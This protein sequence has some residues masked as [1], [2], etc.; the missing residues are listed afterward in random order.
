MSNIMIDVVKTEGGTTKIRFK[1]RDNSDATREDLDTLMK[2]IMG[3]YPKRAGYM[4][5]T[6]ILLEAKIPEEE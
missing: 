5:S 2:V 3:K 1:T 6:T 4:N